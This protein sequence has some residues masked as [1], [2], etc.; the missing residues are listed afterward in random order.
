VRWRD[1]WPGAFGEL[2]MA[3]AF[4]QASLVAAEPSPRK[5][6]KT[7]LGQAA[8]GLK[9]PQNEVDG[10]AILCR[11]S[12]TIL[13]RCVARSFRSALSILFALAILCTRG[14]VFY[15][16]PA[17]NDTHSGS[18]VQPFASIERARVA[19]RQVNRAAGEDIQVLLA[20]GDY[21]LAQTV[22]FSAED[23]GFNGHKVVYQSAG[24]PGSARL[25]G[26]ERVTG[27][28]QS[29]GG[30]W[31][32][33]VGTNRSVT[34]LLEN[35]RRAR[36]ARYPNYEPVP[37]LPV[38]QGRYLYAEGL[39]DSRFVLQ[40]KAADFNPAGI[41]LSH[42][43]VYIWSGGL[44]EWFAD[45]LQIERI[46]PATRQIHLRQESR[47]AI[48]QYNRG[49]RYFLQNSLQFLD[50]DGEFYYDPDAGWLYYRP[51]DGNPNEQFIL[52]P[53]LKIL[54]SFRGES[55]TNLVSNI[56]IRG[57]T[58]EGTAFSDWYRFA[59]T[60]Q[61]SSQLGGGYDRLLDLPEHRA[62]L[63][64]LENTDSIAIEDCHLKNAGYS[65]I[66]GV[67][68]NQNDRFTGNW[69]EHCG[70]SGIWIQGQYPGQ[71][72]VSKRHLI[73]NNLIRHCGELVGH[74]RGIFLINVS[75]SR[76]TH[77][78]IAWCA[79]SA[80]TF[81]GVPFQNQEV[82]CRNNY[83]GYLYL[84]DVMQDSSHTGAINADGLAR[85]TNRVEQVLIENVF[86]HPSC[87]DILPMGIHM[88][89]ESY[90]QIFSNVFV[91][92]V[93][94]AVFF[95]RNIDVHHFS[96]VSWK[97]DFDDSLMDYKNIGVTRDFKY[98]AQAIPVTLQFTR[99]GRDLLLEWPL[100]AESF[101][102]ERSAELGPN[103][104]W[105]Q[106]DT[107]ALPV[108]NRL[109]APIRTADTGFYRLRQQ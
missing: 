70:N 82:Y 10:K 65:A 61:G 19:V 59:A 85:Q 93:Q 6:T 39:Q 64:Y 46:D 22:T 66:Y 102:L 83:L 51:M 28:I 80:V 96:N 91:T 41:D 77:C 40:Y 2:P 52:L 68:Y 73:D 79:R 90:G 108:R 63:I 69:I 15:V 57:L 34:T 87:Q 47:Y 3:P 7:I 58:L 109:R 8:C 98:R 38:A 100:W 101:V 75:D 11:R 94:G 99:F 50:Q 78:E 106:F 44:W 43:Q 29:T 49:G 13:M 33:Q 24:Q 31:K 18:I 67:F 25:L 9:M 35:G 4:R 20:P 30:V 97:P 105:Q 1:Q 5:T 71:G 21:Y 42:G 36:V 37:G 72:D 104:V 92:N 56:I 45:L 107:A 26:G 32:A 81:A 17:G 76:V 86:H 60:V 12:V 16:S 84:H 74:A 103:A 14:A 88:D 89:D 62:G 95:T 48:Y 54:L 23:S 55:P 53:S 27:W